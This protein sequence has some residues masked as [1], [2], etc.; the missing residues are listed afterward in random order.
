M[1]AVEVFPI[2]F[3]DIVERR[4]VL[5]GEDVFEGLEVPLRLHRVAIEREFE[6]NL[7]RLRQAFLAGD[8]KGKILTRLMTTSI[9][10]FLTLIRHALITLGES[11]PKQ[12]RELIDLAA[13]RF[14]LDG[15]PFHAIWDVHEGKRKE[16]SV[17]ARA[18]LAA[19]VENLARAAKEIHGRM[20][21]PTR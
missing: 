9:T 5:F 14:G 16:N 6:T 13:Q 15:S 8:L 19:Y 4:T 10:S 18:T 3:L 11:P 7:V 21:V 2:E 17:D 1:S 12:A 20:A